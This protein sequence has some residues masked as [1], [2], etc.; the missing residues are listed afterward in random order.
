MSDYVMF[1]S[2]QFQHHQLIFPTFQFLFSLLIKTLDVKTWCSQGN[3][4]VVYEEE[5]T[6]RAQLTK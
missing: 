3:D 2:Q 6:L 4:D 5:P 1:Q